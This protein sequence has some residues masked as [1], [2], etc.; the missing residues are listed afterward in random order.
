MGQVSWGG[1]T[2][3]RFPNGPRWAI[4]M[5]PALELVISFPNAYPIMVQAGLKPRPVTFNHVACSGNTFTQIKDKQLLDKPQDDGNNGR[6]P[7]WGKAPE[8]VTITMGGNDIGILNLIATCML[9]FKLW[10]MNCEEVIQYGHDTINSQQFKDDLNRLVKAVVDKGRATAV[11]ERFKVF[12]V[13]YARFF[14]QE[15]T[16][17]NDVDFKPFWNPLTA[18]KLTVERR[19]AMNGLALALN[20]ALSDA[21]DGFKDKGVYWVDY[22][23][24]FEGHRFCDRQEPNPDDPETYFFNYYTKDDPKMAIAQRIFEKIPSYQASVQGAQI[25]STKAD[26]DYINALGEAAK[27]DP[28]AESFMSDTVRMFHPSTRGHQQIRDIVI[29]ALNDIKGTSPAQPAAPPQLKCHGVNGDTWMLSRDQ[30]VSAVEQLCKQDVN[31]KEYFQGS[32]DSVKLSA[33]DTDGSKAL[34]TITDCIGDF[35]VIIDGC[36]GNDPINNPHNYKFGGTY[37]SPGGWE[38]KLDPTAKK[39]TEDSCDV[40]YKFVLDKFE[41]RGKNFPDAKLGANG[42][43][44]KSQIKGCGALTDWHFEWTPN[45]VKYQ[46]YA[47]GNLPVG[48][49]SCMGRAVVSAGGAGAGNCHGSG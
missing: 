41:V 16:Q 4:L 2:L 36:D 38:F 31:E 14:N 15:T 49:K 45:D 7:A 18:Q 32:V 12:V 6:R 30:V 27:D 43:G 19:T 46:W 17:C 40:G 39:P 35:K 10:G 22:D 11:G 33:H 47:H 21:V 23:Q 28:E 25:V 20:K 1:V 48:A 37:T 42:E 26:E 24:D 13:G 9:S 29:K 44:L 8:F 34:S 3:E 5:H